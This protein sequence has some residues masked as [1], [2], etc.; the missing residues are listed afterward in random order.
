MSEIIHLKQLKQFM[1]Y[2]SIPTN[3][4]ESLNQQIY[5]MGYS[6]NK[7]LNVFEDDLLRSPINLTKQVQV[8]NYTHN[9]IYHAQELYNAGERHG[10]KYVHLLKSREDF[11]PELIDPESEAAIKYRLEQ[12]AR[13]NSTDYADGKPR[14][15]W[16]RTAP[17]AR[18][19]FG[20]KMAENIEEE[21]QT[22][23]KTKPYSGPEI[24]PVY[25]TDPNKFLVPALLWGPSNQ[26]NGLKESIALALK[27][28]RTL[29]LP[30]FYRHY[31][32]PFCQNSW[33]D[34][35]DP[36]L[37][38]NVGKLRQLLPI[39]YV[40]EIAS[41]CPNGPEAIF[42]ARPIDLEKPRLHIRYLH[43]F[44]IYQTNFIQN[45]QRN[46]KWFLTNYKSLTGK[47][48]CSQNENLKLT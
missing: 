30:K 32:D 7:S 23:P 22:K 48:G 45:K 12:E 14:K 16:F 1:D 9:M 36:S 35:I 11:N 5:I 39:I 34:A 24:K 18:W 6:K 2:M 42:P 38:I 44:D 31:L 41:V 10:Q 3:L 4:T 47:D 13:F 33:T 15:D 28:N 8:I 19:S 26:I 29:I 37:R 25:F 17:K 40:S 43:F 21:C 27:L 20:K 46:N